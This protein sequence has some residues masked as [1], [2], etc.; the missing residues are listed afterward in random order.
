MNIVYPDNINIIDVIS[1]LPG[2]INVSSNFSF[3]YR[4]DVFFNV[5][6]NDKGLFLLTRCTDKRYWEYGNLWN[7]K[8]SVGDQY[9]NDILPVTYNLYCD[10][11]N[12]KIAINQSKDLIKNMNEHLNNYAFM[13]GYNL[14]KKEFE[15]S[16]ISYMRKKKMELIK[17]TQSII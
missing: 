6:D 15:T 3:D 16:F 4:L 12:E 11:I 14:N 13:E 9:E 8:L 2:I 10:E 5:K 1:S 7:I 17:L